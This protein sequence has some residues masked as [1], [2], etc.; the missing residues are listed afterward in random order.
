MRITVTLIAVSLA[1][2]ACDRGEAPQLVIEQEP[3]V[4]ALITTVLN[5][6]GTFSDVPFA[7]LIATST[8]K[9]VLPVNPEDP[10]D[11]EIL[12]LIDEA[13]AEVS[14]SRL[15]SLHQHALISL[16][17]EIDD[18]LVLQ[19]IQTSPD[20]SDEGKRLII[21]RSRAREN[22][23]FARS[24]ELRDALANEGITVRDTP[25]GT[26]WEYLS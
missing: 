11:A 26:V 6:G 5:G 24:D 4:P 10:V 16:L 7:E 23:D 2:S 21:E 20:I 15:D 8:G 17:E 3:S 19:L 12:A 25:S 9:Q 1:F 14:A 13:F 18:L 22:K